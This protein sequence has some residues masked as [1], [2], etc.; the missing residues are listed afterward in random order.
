M[1][2]QPHF[3]FYIL[4]S[5]I[6]AKGGGGQILLSTIVWIVGCMSFIKL[7]RIPFWAG[8]PNLCPSL[9]DIMQSGKPPAP[10]LCN[11][12]LHRYADLF[13]SLLR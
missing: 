3:K 1:F 9:V 11:S 6:I 13:D 5:D 4:V 7:C 8:S 12:F 10:A 2:E